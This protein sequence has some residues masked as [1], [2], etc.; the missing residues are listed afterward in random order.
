MLVFLWTKTLQNVNISFYYEGV[1]YIAL[2]TKSE[3]QWHYRSGKILKTVAHLKNHEHTNVSKW[4]KVLI[5]Y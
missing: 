1:H 5:I 3:K 4:L 2:Q